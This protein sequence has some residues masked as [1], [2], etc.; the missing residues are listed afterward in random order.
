MSEAKPEARRRKTPPSKVT[1]PVLKS[2]GITMLAFLLSFSL[3]AP[4]TA[5]LW[6]FFSAPGK[7]DFTLPDLYMYVADNRPVRHLDDRIV[8]VDID[9]AG[10]REIADLLSLL[11]L[12]G[13]KAVGLDVLFDKPSGD[14]ASLMEAIRSVPGLVVPVAVEENDKKFAV[15][16][17]SFF[18]DSLPTVS[19]GAANFITKSAKSSV[20]EYAVDYTMSDGSKLPSFPTALAAIY[21]PDAATRLRSHNRARGIA[22]YHSRT[23][24]VIPLEE[25]EDHAENFTD[26]I[27]LIGAMNEAS[28]IHS[29]PI[30]AS[31]S[32]LLIHAHA[33]ST[34][35]DGKWISEAP[36]YTDYIAA[37]II[38][39]L[40]V[41]ATLTI[42]NKIRGLLMRLTQ[43]LTVY[44]AVRIGFWLFID[45]DIIC[46]F[47]NTLLMILF[48]LFA[49]DIWNGITAILDMA[50]NKYK[51]LTDK[52]IASCENSL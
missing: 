36:P 19:Y 9:R 37:F 25:A 27:V 17:K 7:G 10:R 45:H 46:N 12:C 51:K 38:C 34:I 47:S 44:L 13:P 11:S 35:L 39:F 30:S 43:V 6:S 48:G 20:R 8:I 1:L 2:L 18:T 31:M 41:L 21:D 40:I 32:G 26:K 52:E 22:A 4:F 16:E 49:L 50:Y 42:K 24:D 33:L 28:D 15:S 5:S 23:Y 3:S 29:T 14:D